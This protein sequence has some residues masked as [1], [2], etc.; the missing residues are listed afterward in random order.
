M[1]YG[2]QGGIFEPRKTIELL[3]PSSGS[4]HSHDGVFSLKGSHFIINAASL[5]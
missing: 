1:G 2:R 3:S 5:Q 4:G